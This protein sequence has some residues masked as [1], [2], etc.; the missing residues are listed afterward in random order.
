MAKCNNETKNTSIN[1][2]MPLHNQ[3]QQ[4][5]NKAEKNNQTETP[6]QNRKTQQYI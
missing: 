2:S 4:L 1:V 6:Q 3:T 5:N